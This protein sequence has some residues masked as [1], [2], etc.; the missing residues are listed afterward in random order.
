[1]NG[2]K[3]GSLGRIAASELAKPKGEAFAWAFGI[4]SGSSPANYRNMDKTLLT[5]VMTGAC[6]SIVVC[7]GWVV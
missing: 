6:E 4:L 2:F 1:M 5:G 3:L 7:G